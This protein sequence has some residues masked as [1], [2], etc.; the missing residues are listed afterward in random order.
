ML[1]LSLIPAFILATYY[2]GL[3]GDFVFDDFSNIL[4]QPGVAMQELSWASIKSAALSM[5]SRPIAFVS[6]GLN[7]LAAGF[8]PIYFKAV[9]IVIHIIN[10]LLVF[11]VIRLLL[12]YLFGEDTGEGKRSIYIAAVISLAWALHPVNLTNV[13][14]IVQR[15]NSLSALFVLAGM[16]SYIQGRVSL[17]ANPLKGW[18]FMATSIFIFLPLAWYSKENGALLPLFLFIIELT[19]FRFSCI[20]YSPT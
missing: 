19:I 12:S 4:L 2:P 8:N 13:L 10:A 16:L 15:M 1:V 3:S 14:Y 11:T 6:F 18:L 17:D 7:H 5:N 9:N 20:R